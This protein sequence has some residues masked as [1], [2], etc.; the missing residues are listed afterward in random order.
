MVLQAKQQLETTGAKIL[1][2]VINKVDFTGGEMYYR[3]YQYEK[4][5]EPGLGQRAGKNLL[6]LY[7]MSIY[8]KVYYF[9]IGIFLLASAADGSPRMQIL[10][11]SA[12]GIFLE[13]KVW[14]H[15]DLDTVLEVDKDGNINLPLLGTVQVTEFSFTGDRDK[16]HRSCR[17]TGHQRP[18]CLGQDTEKEIFCAGRGQGTGFI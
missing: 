18:L 8:R 4:D 1:G 15:P 13:I 2:V 5:E 10:S 9:L 7:T 17:G 11:G 14:R 12:A 6:D 3:Y 16:T